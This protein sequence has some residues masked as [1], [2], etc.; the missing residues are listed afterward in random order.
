M[1]FA[2]ALMVA[3]VAFAGCTDDEAAADAT[4][5]IIDPLAGLPTLHGWIL[6]AAAVP[7]PNVDI[8]ASGGNAYMTASTDADGFYGFEGL[9]EGAAIVLTARADG[10]ITQSK[11][12]TLQPQAKVQLNFTLER[13][14]VIEPYHETLGPFQGFIGCQYVTETSGERT[15]HDCGGDSNE[16]TWQIRVGK[17][18]A[19]GVIEIEWESNTEASQNLRATVE[20]S[21]AGSCGDD[22]EP[23]A[24]SIGPSRLRV[25]IGSLVA[26]KYF[27]S[28]GTM[29]LRVTVDPNNAANESNAGTAAAAS[30]PFEAI[31]SMFYH[32]PPPPGY[33][34]DA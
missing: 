18:F 17:D 16:N 25:E 29:L 3:T 9:P 4:A 5:E 15:V 20:C 14:P 8:E 33:T 28:G 21:T 24:E 1:R 22:I 31:A 27:P 7:V 12:T 6:D 23:F 32:S 10:F 26:E 34:Y 30:Q 11:Q 2:V 19:G 13:Q